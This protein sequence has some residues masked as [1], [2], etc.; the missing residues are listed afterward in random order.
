MTRN[1]ENVVDAKV[2]FEASESDPKRMQWVLLISSSVDRMRWHTLLDSSFDYD[3]RL[4]SLPCQ[5]LS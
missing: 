5:I 2:L 4:K 1:D 3:N